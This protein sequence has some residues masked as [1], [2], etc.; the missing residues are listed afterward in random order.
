MNE[1]LSDDSRAVLAFVRDHPA[2]TED[3]ISRHLGIKLERIMEAIGQL[4]QH[5][6]ILSHM[7]VTEVVSPT[8]YLG[9]PEYYPA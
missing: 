6:L 9:R 2:S 4:V 3:E 1:L 8:M 5:K 7:R